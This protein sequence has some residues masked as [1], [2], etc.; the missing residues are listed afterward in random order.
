[1]QFA[2]GEKKQARRENE[3][4]FFVRI[5]E[6]QRGKSESCVL[7]LVISDVTCIGTWRED[8]EMGPIYTEETEEKEA[9]TRVGDEA[10][11]DNQSLL[12]LQAAKY[13]RILALRDQKGSGECLEYRKIENSLQVSLLP[14]CQLLRREPQKLRNGSSQDHDSLY[15]QNFTLKGSCQEALRD[16]HAVALG[17]KATLPYSF[18]LSSQ[19]SFII[20]ITTVTVMWNF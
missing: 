3:L 18:L 10:K 4:T 7:F 5:L 19:I 13:P 14:Q 8:P 17:V 2:W 6:R 11:A 20:L 16:K 1:M 12:D 15:L 9:V